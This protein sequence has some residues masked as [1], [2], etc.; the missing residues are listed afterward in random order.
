MLRVG[1]VLALS[2]LVATVAISAELSQPAGS[3]AAATTGPFVAKSIAQAKAS[4]VDTRVVL[5]GRVV[6]VIKSDEFLMADE[7]GELLVFTPAGALDGLDAAGAVVE[8]VGRI[9]Q[10]FMYTEIQAESVKVIP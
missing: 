10:N 4:G 2:L 8:V 9:D 1:M 6:K 5:T 7:T 3:A